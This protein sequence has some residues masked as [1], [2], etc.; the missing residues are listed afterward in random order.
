MLALYDAA[1]FQ[2]HLGPAGDAV[3]SH[4]GR[5]LSHHAA[6]GVDRPVHAGAVGRRDG[7]VAPTARR[8][9]R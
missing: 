9:R 3:L 8:A 7:G 5:V 2:A 6:A 4:S 1:A